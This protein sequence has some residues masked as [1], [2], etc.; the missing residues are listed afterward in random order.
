MRGFRTA[1]GPIREIVILSA[2]RNGTNFLCE[3]LGG[4]REI[5][6]YFE[7]FNPNGAMGTAV[8]PVLSRVSAMFGREVVSAQDPDLVALFRTEP[9]R[10]LWM[11]RDTARA[12]R[13][14]CISYKIFPGQLSPAAL[15][16]VL[17]RDGV[18]VI[19][20]SRTRLDVYISYLKARQTN[21]WKNAPTAGL[22]CEVEV[23]AFLDWAEEQDRWFDSCAEL[24]RRTGRPSA[25]FDYDADI[26]VAKHDLLRHLIRVMRRVGTEVTFN[27]EADETLFLRQDARVS[28]FR[29]IGNGDAVEAELR[30]LGRL[31]YALAAPLA[32]RPPSRGR[33]ARLFGR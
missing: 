30:R 26:D 14:K 10:A 32:A 33:I 4:L 23:A 17:D 19:L 28:P 27:P 29:K 22:A 3:C 20:L 25:V 5:D 11:L 24:L 13:R 15:A 21:V 8:P 6:A 2:P 16:T 9:V 31:D 18:F 7:L 12:R 1:Q